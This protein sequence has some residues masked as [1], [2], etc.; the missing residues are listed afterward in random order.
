MPDKKTHIFRIV[1]WAAALCSGSVLAEIPPS[2]SPIETVRSGNHQQIRAGRGSHEELPIHHP[3]PAPGVLAGRKNHRTTWRSGLPKTLP[4][5]DVDLTAEA[6]SNSPAGKADV[7]P[8]VSARVKQLTD[9][10]AGRSLQP[11][12]ERMIVGEGGA[13]PKQ[14]APWNGDHLLADATN[15][16]DE[17]VSIASSPIS[18]NLY[19]VFEATDLGG[20]DRD[21]HIARSLDGGATWMVWEM[22]SFSQDEYHPELV[23]DGAGYLL[24]TWIRADGYILRSKTSNP[25]DP[26]VWEWVRGLNVGETCATP[27]IAARGSGVNGKVFIA[28]AWQTINYDLFAYEWTLI[29]MYSTDGGETITYDYF[30]PDGYNDYWP[31]VALKGSNCYFINAEQDYFTGEVEILVAADDI[32]GFFASPV[33]LSDWTG[34]DCRFPV[35]ANQASNVYMAFQLDFDDGLGNVDGDIVYCYSW[36]G[37]LEIYGPFDMVSDEY[38]SVG[39]AIYAKNG[40]VGCLW[41]DA[42]A[43]ADEFY[44]A[45]R[46]AGGFGH[47]DNWGVIEIASDFQYVNPTFHST[48]GASSGEKLHAAWID[49]RDFPTQ[50]L[51]VYT[52]ERSAE[53]NLAPYTPQGWESPLAANLIQGV[54]STGLLA[55]GDTTFVSFAFN[56]SGLTD[57]TADFHVR[58]NVDGTEEASWIV[59]GGLSTSSYVSV[60]DYPLISTAGSHV[61]G[62]EVDYLGEIAESD[63]SDNIH[64]DTLEFID[65]NPVLRFN[66]GTVTHEFPAPLLKRGETI[67]LAGRLPVRSRAR[68]EVVEPR[69]R[70]AAEAAGPAVPVPVIIVP[71]ERVDAAAILLSLAGSDR[72]D[73]RRM[74]AAGLKDQSERNRASLSDSWSGPVLRGDMSEPRA[75][76]LSGVFASRMNVDAIERLADDPRI[77]RLWLDDRAGEPFFSSP[78]GSAVETSP[79]ASRS[80]QKQSAVAWH[81]TRIGAPAAW[82]EGYDGTGIL[83]G[84]LDTGVAYDHPDLAAHLW[85]GSP[86]YPNHGYD[87]IDEDDNPYDGDTGLFHGTHTAGL[88]VGDGASGTATG[89]APGAKLM[90]LRCMPGMFTDLVEAIQICLNNGVDLISFSAGWINPSV[91]LREANRYNSEILLAA[92]IPWICAGGNGDNVGGHL[93]VPAD[94]A[95]PGDSPNPWYGSGGHSA[96]IAAGALNAVNGAWQFSSHGPTEWNIS[97]SPEGFDDYPYPPGLIKPDLAAPGVGITSTTPAASYVSYDGT[98]MATPQVAG[99]CAILMQASPGLLPAQLAEALEGGALDLTTSPASSGRDNYTGAGLLD[100][101]ASIDLLP[102]TDREDFFVCNDGL[103]PLSISQIAW[104][105]GWLQ[106]TTAGGT[107]APGDSLSLSALFDPTGFAEGAYQDDALFT[108]NDPAGPHALPVT[109]I[110][111]NATEVGDGAPP[112]LVRSH[113]ENRPNPF[114]PQT[115][116]RFVTIERGRVALS[117]YSMNGRLVR[118]LVDGVLEPGRHDALWDGRDDR[119]R[120]LSSGVYAARLE[121]SGGSATSRKITLLR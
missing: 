103:L 70:L 25:D 30:V 15:M 69:L 39:P 116:I 34:M 19:A 89:V 76:W 120:D 74:I 9:L 58:L 65:G 20:T 81:L 38:E 47:P 21:I 44:L 5:E 98:S 51:N 68:M 117:I 121:L 43:G 109:M 82:S 114:N 119:G 2:R 72:A 96:V 67:K 40:M 83:I 115:T 92:G 54:R 36:D 7:S 56:N 108:S 57:L 93:P 59:E 4:F 29:W 66:P 32:S 12:T 45:S 90:I 85:D 26:L 62:F 101:P 53:A 78:R 102:A 106:V 50:G 13:F 41:L 6:R 60:E 22:P 42:P 63:E 73:R 79:L 64:F 87:T 100:I 33:N 111:G 88:I 118:R 1:A 105:A 31:D 77:A 86:A 104:S 14:A 84:H 3:M 35:I 99:A 97:P 27:A 48:A 80:S 55:A 113:L 28:A 17:Y 46:Q 24:V 112:F 49:R 71:V 16:N 110:I 11:D 23:I 18:D 61:I 8:L 95:S 94:I 75:L 37:L 10:L 52:S 91:D 107:I